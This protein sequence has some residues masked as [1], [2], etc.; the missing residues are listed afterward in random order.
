MRTS[1]ARFI[2]FL[3]VLACC[4]ASL[5][6]A[7][8]SPAAG[9]QMAQLS[10]DLTPNKDLHGQIQGLVISYALKSGEMSNSPLALRFDTLEPALE[11]TSDQITQLHASDAQGEIHFATPERELQDDRTFR[12]FKSIPRNQRNRA[13]RRGL[14]STGPCA[15]CGQFCVSVPVPFPCR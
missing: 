6:V 5:P 3:L 13:L 14:S 7:S 1:G 10:L 15:A 4:F 11:R 2:S 12:W 8:A 9:S